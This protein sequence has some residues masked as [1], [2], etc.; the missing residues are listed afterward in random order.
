MSCLFAV[1]IGMAL[2]NKKK[3]KASLL[4]VFDLVLNVVNSE[5]FGLVM[6]L[7]KFLTLS[8]FS[9]L[10]NCLINFFSWA[11][12]SGYYIHKIADDLNKL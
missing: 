1:L 10:L 5:V 12:L 8:F 11:N 6:L 9:N 4:L 3:V 2:R 7:S